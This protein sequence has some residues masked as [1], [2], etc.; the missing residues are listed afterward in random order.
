MANPVPQFTHFIKTLARNH[1]NFAYI[2]LVSSRVAG[3]ETKADADA[4]VNPSEDID[5]AKAAWGDRPFLSCGGWTPDSALSHME[6]NGTEN[7][8]VVF[9]RHFISNV[10]PSCFALLLSLLTM[11]SSPTYLKGS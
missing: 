5:F 10:C 11:L 7:E 3:S 1:P 4:N 9:G 2:H 8:A 6:G